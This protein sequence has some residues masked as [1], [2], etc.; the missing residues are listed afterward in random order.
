M[1][2]EGQWLKQSK[3]TTNQSIN[4]PINQPTNQSI[5]Q[6]TN[7]SI[8]EV[9]LHPAP[10]AELSDGGLTHRALLYSEGP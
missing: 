2:G 7:Q 9:Q 5:N 3:R 1:Q 10:E 6:P 4:Q 8:N